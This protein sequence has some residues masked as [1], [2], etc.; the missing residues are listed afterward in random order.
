MDL[1]L[2]PVHPQWPQWLLYSADLCDLQMACLPPYSF[3]AEGRHSEQFQA[4]LSQELWEVRVAVVWGGGYWT[5]DALMTS[6][7]CRNGCETFGK[8]SSTSQTV[9]HSTNVSHYS[10]G[11]DDVCWK[12]EQK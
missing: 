11:H 5:E 8:L 12:R 7:K 10:P 9:P 1:T 6:I 4:S 3:E 2:E